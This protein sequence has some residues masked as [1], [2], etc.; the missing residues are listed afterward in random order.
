[1]GAV[2]FSPRAKLLKAKDKYGNDPSVFLAESDER[3]PGKTYGFTKVLWEDLIEKE[4]MFSLMAR[5]KGEVGHTAA[6]M[7]APMLSNVAPGTEIREK[8]KQA[9]IFSEIWAKGPMAGCKVETALVG[10]VLPL[11]AADGI[12]KASGEFQQVSSVFFDEFQPTFGSTYLLDEIARFTTIIES[13]DRGGGEM[14]RPLKIYMSSNTITKANPYHDAFGLTGVIDENTKFYRGNRVVYQKVVNTAVQNARINSAFGQLLNRDADT[15][16]SSNAFANDN[17]IAVGKPGDDWGTGTYMGTIY[18]GKDGY[19]VRS[20]DKV[21]YLYLDRRVDSTSTQVF[22]ISKGDDP[23]KR[24]LRGTRMGQWI[25]KYSNDGRM[26]FSDLST[27][28][29]AQN[30]LM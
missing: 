19:A 9:G 20:F 5:L 10:Y 16:N 30:Y 25:R 14:V 23:T 18:V 21:G 13:I 26:R 29:M 7:L 6:P 2:W 27:Q 28:V 4:E 12:K 11:K 1:M 15:Y 17:E 3:G 22:R 24:I 8:V